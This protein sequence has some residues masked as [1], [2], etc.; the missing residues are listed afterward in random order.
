[1]VLL[2]RHVAEHVVQLASSGLAWIDIEVLW[3]QGERDISGALAR[4]MTGEA[5][6]SCPVECRRSAYLAHRI[7]SVHEIRRS[8]GKG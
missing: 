7:A 2:A 6:M 4:F 1:M 5:R 3:E 8:S